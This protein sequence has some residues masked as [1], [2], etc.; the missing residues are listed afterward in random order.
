MQISGASQALQGFSGI[1]N[2]SVRPSPPAD[3]PAPAAANPKA[4]AAPREAKAESAP[5]PERREAPPED[6]GTDVPRGSV[7]DIKA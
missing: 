2:N 6:P 7:V 1:Q 5:A 3:S 4:E